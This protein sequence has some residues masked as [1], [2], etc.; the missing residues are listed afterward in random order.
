MVKS[1]PAMRETRF[2]PWVR[3]IWTRK[4]PPT[5]VS[6][7]G[8]SHGQRSLVGYSSRDCKESDTTEVTLHTHT[9]T[10]KKHFLFKRTKY[11]NYSMI[12]SLMDLEREGEISYFESGQAS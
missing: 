1:P 10:D 3:K 7:P 12:A 9:E 6:V 11:N 8:E 2:D 4:W 5:P